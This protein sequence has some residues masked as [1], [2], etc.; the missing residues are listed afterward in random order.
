MMGITEDKKKIYDDIIA[1]LASTLEVS[2]EEI[3][4][5]IGVDSGLPFDSL[6]LYEFVIDLEEKYNIKISD[7][8]LDGIK[9]IGDIVDLVAALSGKEG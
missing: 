3:P 5:D 9:D 2:P 1:L 4:D 6:Q 8:A 7:E